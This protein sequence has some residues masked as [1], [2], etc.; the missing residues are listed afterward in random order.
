MERVSIAL[1]S[2]GGKLSRWRR[3]LTGQHGRP[4]WNLEPTLSHSWHPFALHGLFLNSSDQAG[5]V[6]K[7]V[8]TW[9]Q[10]GFHFISKKNGTVLEWVRI[11]ARA[12]LNEET[13]RH[14][15]EQFQLKEE[16]W[17]HWRPGVAER[18]AVRWD[19]WGSQNRIPRMIWRTW[20]CGVLIRAGRLRHQWR[21]AQWG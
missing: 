8:S 19:I 18:N 2:M 10:G 7:R 4:C 6:V 3:R 14:E 21:A 17:R 16:D 9:I 5:T 1:G 12:W 15:R 13:T 20:H 11:W